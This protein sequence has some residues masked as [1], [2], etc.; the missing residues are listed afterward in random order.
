MADRR[1]ITGFE[2]FIAAAAAHFAFSPDQHSP[3]PSGEA[4]TE[5]LRRWWGEAVALEVIAPDTYRW[6]CPGCR[7]TVTTRAEDVF[8]W[9][10]FDYVL[11]E[12]CPSCAAALHG[13][14]PGGGD[15]GA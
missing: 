8:M 7:T 5:A 6:R 4:G 3:F 11:W 13:E 10:M 14:G 1:P 12:H 2:Q 15:G 9:P